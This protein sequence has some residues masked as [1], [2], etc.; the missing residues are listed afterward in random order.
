MLGTCLRPCHQPGNIPLHRRSCLPAP[1]VCHVLCSPPSPVLPPPA[2]PLLAA[3][4]RRRRPPGLQLAVCFCADRLPRR[5]GQR[6]LLWGCGRLPDQIRL[7]SCWRGP[8]T[9]CRTSALASDL[10]V[11][12]TV[13]GR[14]VR[15]GGEREREERHGC[16]LES[17]VMRR[18]ILLSS[19]NALE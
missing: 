12:G 11:R 3:A 13:G 15:R 6:R 14:G 9:H 18:E 10:L 5:P 4:G 2:E 7:S 8:G 1:L 19:V 17:R 16:W